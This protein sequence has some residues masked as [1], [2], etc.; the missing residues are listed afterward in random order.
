[1]WY[2]VLIMQQ[3]YSIYTCSL[4]YF[5]SKV[6]KVFQQFSTVVLCFVIYFYVLK[7]FYES[8][9]WLFVSIIINSA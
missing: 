5:I 1:M 2:V 7:Y 4:C 9:K 8:R 6:A 3:L